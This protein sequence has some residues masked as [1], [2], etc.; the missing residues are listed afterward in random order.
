MSEELWRRVP[1]WLLGAGLLSLASAA[2]VQMYRGDALI[3]ADGAVFAKECVPSAEVQALYS[4]LKELERRPYP[5]TEERIRE[6]V[7]AAL[8]DGGYPSAEEVRNAFMKSELALTSIAEL[9]P[10]GPPPPSAAVVARFLFEN[11]LDVVRGPKGE[12]GSDGL[13]GAPGIKGDK[14]PRGFRGDPAAFPEGIIVASVRP[15]PDI[16]RE[17]RSYDNAGGR[18]LIGVGASTDTRKETKAFK[19]EET[20]GAY[21]HL[22]TVKEMPKHDHDGIFGGDGGKAGMNNEYAYH[23]S[24]YRKIRSE[25]GG[26][27]HNNM[28]P[29]VAVY[30]CKREF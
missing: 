15:C 22:L 27:P 25:G 24:G 5:I 19:F 26:E 23:S 4:R 21:Q 18:F 6:V 30:F 9:V 7:E 10:E 3:C 13:P 29:Y 20:N 1:N 28:P 11:H 12:D 8:P 17:W 2:I 14:G 16:G